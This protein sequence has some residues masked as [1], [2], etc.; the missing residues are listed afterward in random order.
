MLFRSALLQKPKLLILD[1]ATSE[2]NSS[3]EKKILSNIC[4]HKE[5]NGIIII[6]H[7]VRNKKIADQY[8]EIVNNNILERNR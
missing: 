6:S 5:L 8:L 2:I 7:N 4:N 3:L 1:E